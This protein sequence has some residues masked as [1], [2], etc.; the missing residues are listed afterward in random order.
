VYK[1][2][3]FQKVLFVFCNLDNLRSTLKDQQGTI[4]TKFSD[5]KKVIYRVKCFTKVDVNDVFLKLF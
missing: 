1:R 4:A 2:E 3:N 5:Q